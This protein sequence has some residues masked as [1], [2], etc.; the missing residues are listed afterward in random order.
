MARP[1]KDGLKVTRKRQADGTIKEYYYDRAT[2]TFLA[3]DRTAAV[4]RQAV[5]CPKLISES[6]ELPEGT[7]GWL[8]ERYKQNSRY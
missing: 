7:F 6:A 5:L 4:R 3:H 1:R 8:I 2:K